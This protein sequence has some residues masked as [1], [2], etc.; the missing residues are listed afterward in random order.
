MVFS[1]I[2]LTVSTKTDYVISVSGKVKFRIIGLQYIHTGGAVNEILQLRSSRFQTTHSTRPNAILFTN[3]G[4]NHIVIP[5]TDPIEFE[6][7]IYNTLDLEILQINGSAP[8]NFVGAVL[9]LEIVP[10]Q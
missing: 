7:E 5:P 8:T 6:G 2:A 1:Q 10:L 3:D 4:G 9:T